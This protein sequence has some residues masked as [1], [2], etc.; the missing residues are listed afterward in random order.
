MNSSVKI[1]NYMKLHRSKI[2]AGIALTVLLLAASPMSAFAHQIETSDDTPTSSEQSTNDSSN[3]SDSTGNTHTTR[4]GRYGTDGIT[5][6]KTTSDTSESGDD[7][8]RSRAQKLLSDKRQNRLERTQAQRQKACEQHQ[9]GID[10]RF[11]TLG[12]KADRF[13]QHFNEVF[14]KV[15]A[16]QANKQLTV[17]DYD[18]LVADVTAK[19]TAATTAVAT[20][21]SLSGTK[22]DCT[23]TD[24]ATS[25]AAVKEA[26]QDARTALQAYRA[27]LKNLVKALQAAKDTDNS[28]TSET[29]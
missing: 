3:D 7:S 19:Q 23:V 5:T 10:N 13:L 12:D 17:A 25:V 16:Y 26:A 27:S 2:M 14:T 18:A 28:A 11:A 9:D 24:P 22:I 29:N 21:K 20:L 1:R 15:Q 8:L 4:T 6:I